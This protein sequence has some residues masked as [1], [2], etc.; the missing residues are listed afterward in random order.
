MASVCK[1]NPKT[2]RQASRRRAQIDRL[3]D[4]ELFKALGEP[5]R[6]RLLACLVKCGRAC[7]VTEVAQCCEIDF[8]VVSRHLASL[9]KAG[10]LHGEKKGRTVWYGAAPDLADRF[11]A[12]ADAIDEWGTSDSPD[13]DGRSCC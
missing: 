12:L 13:P 4:S 1:P 3:L 9:A 8:S 11:R 2:P 6:A 10:V 5:T 7:S